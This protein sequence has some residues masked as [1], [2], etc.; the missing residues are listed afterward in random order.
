[1]SAIVDLY[2][3]SNVKEHPLIKQIVFLETFNIELLMQQVV[4]AK[5]LIDNLMDHV[6]KQQEANQF[7]SDDTPAYIDV[8]LYRTI[9]EIQMQQM[10]ILR[11]LTI[12]ARNAP[13]VLQRASMEVME[14]DE[15]IVKIVS[16]GNDDDDSTYAGTVADRDNVKLLDSIDKLLEARDK[17]LSSILDNEDNLD[18]LERHVM[19]GGDIEQFDPNA[20]VAIPTHVSD[21]LDD[22]I[23]IDDFEDDFD[24]A[25]EVN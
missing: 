14:N 22:E 3:D 17:S 1:M 25:E 21:E 13:L 24:D 8:N 9:M 12:N 7:L 4:N 5:I 10:N 18:D 23:D 20:V 15:S 2:I 19:S 6:S 11:E 16:G